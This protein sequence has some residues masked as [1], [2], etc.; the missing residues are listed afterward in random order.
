MTK[1]LPSK[2][3]VTHHLL[4]GPV[5]IWHGEENIVVN[6]KWCSLYVTSALVCASHRGQTGGLTNLALSVPC[7]NTP[8]RHTLCLKL[9]VCNNW[10]LDVLYKGLSSFKKKLQ[11]WVN[12]SSV[13]SWPEHLS[14]WRASPVL[15]Y[16]Q[17][18]YLNAH[19]VMPNLPWGGNTG[20]INTHCQVFLYIT[21]EYWESQ[22]ENTVWSAYT[23]GTLLIHRDFSKLRTLTLPPNQV[24]MI[25][26]PQYITYINAYGRILCPWINIR[27]GLRSVGAPRQQTLR[28]P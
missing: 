2:V 14:P 13:I 20:Q 25:S 5:W 7:G 22:Q 23:Q 12:R 24:A 18:L 8:L 21:A 19:G 10:S 26:T 1:L 15:H 28:G 16:T 11:L 17:I 9:L 3:P 4:P 6:L 27:A